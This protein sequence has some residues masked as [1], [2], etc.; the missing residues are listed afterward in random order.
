[1]DAADDV[2]A[3]VARY[4]DARAEA[5]AKPMPLDDLIVVISHILSSQIPPNVTLH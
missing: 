5:G 3:F 4:G 2:A 1:M